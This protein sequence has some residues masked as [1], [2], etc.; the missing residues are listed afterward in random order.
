MNTK[1]IH[2]GSSKFD[3]DL[4]KG[5]ENRKYWN[6]PRF[7]LWTS[8]IDS[9]YGWK[10]WCESEDFALSSLEKSYTVRLKKFSKV[11][12]IN[13][14]ADLDKLEWL[15]SMS[16]IYPDFESISKKYDA[17]HLTED[18][19]WSTRLLCQEKS[20]NGW[21]CESVLIMNKECIE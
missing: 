11:L 15:S 6:K 12:T 18:G 1:L 4:F 16:I 13:N 8:P 21:D 14:K 2:Y 5:V 7:G 17:I 9:N 19:V 10:D 3:P 20:F